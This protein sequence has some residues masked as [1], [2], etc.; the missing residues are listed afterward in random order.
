MIQRR[1]T[2]DV[3]PVIGSTPI[4]DLVAREI[5]EKVLR[6]I[7]DRGTLETAHRVRGTLSQI[8]RYGV[9]CGCANAMQP[10]T[11]EVR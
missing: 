7:E 4:A 5:L 9:A 3:Y 1:L 2:N 6:P 10:S 11:C 8:M